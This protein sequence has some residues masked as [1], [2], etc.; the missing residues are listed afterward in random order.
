[1]P[2]L[3]PKP[4]KKNA[5]KGL[6]PG[7]KTVPINASYFHPGMYIDTEIYLKVNDTYVLFCKNL[8][9]DESILHKMKSRIA[10]SDYDVY[11]SEEYYDEIR[12]QSADF[13]TIE[14]IENIVDVSDDISVERRKLEKQAEMDSF[15]KISQDTQ[16]LLTDIVS[17]STLQNETFDGVVRNISEKVYNSD[18]SI[19]LQ[20]INDIKERGDYLYSHSTN[21]GTLNGFIGK[22]LDMSTED[23]DK[24]I[25]TGLVHDIGKLRIS[26]A[27]M[28]KPARLTDAEYEIVKG[29]S[30][31]SYDILTE[32]GMTDPQILNGVLYHHERNNGTG[33]P[34]G[35]TGKQI[36]LFAKITALSDV[37]DAMISKRPYKDPHSPFEILAEFSRSRYSDLDIHIVSTFLENIPQHF[38]GKRAVL[39]DGRS[40]RITYLN[41]NDFEYPIVNVDNRLIK[42]NKFLKCIAV[43]SFSLEDII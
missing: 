16:T 26:P 15:A 42:T 12:R 28:N 17:S 37:Y 3:I 39:S 11:V 40:A 31:H 34:K 14:N 25:R 4:R 19:I 33:Y 23:I 27:I 43:D 35:L 30:T 13:E 10:N 38:I 29:H 36:P 32:S 41:P 1:M 22:W 5:A 8:I 9:I 20:C 2:S 24:L 18:V 6:P 7:V 21:V